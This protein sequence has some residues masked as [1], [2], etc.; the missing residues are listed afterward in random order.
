M[1][2]EKLIQEMLHKGVQGKGR[3]GK[4]HIEKAAT[5]TVRHE[6]SEYLRVRICPNMRRTIESRITLQVGP[7]KKYKIVSTNPSFCRKFSAK[8][9]TYRVSE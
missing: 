2:M 7:E 3:G 4:M 1:S 9:D 5:L 8:V 6:P